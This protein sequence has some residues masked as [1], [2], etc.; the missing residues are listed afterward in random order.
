MR[1]MFSLNIAKTTRMWFA[2]TLLRFRSLPSCT[3][4][5]VCTVNL[6]AAN[7]KDIEG[8]LRPTSSSTAVVYKFVATRI[9]LIFHSAWTVGKVDKFI[10]ESQLSGGLVDQEALAS[11]QVEQSCRAV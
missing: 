4:D 10:G 7:Q 1:E 8:F 2:N 5:T 11:Y 6:S 3:T 9:S